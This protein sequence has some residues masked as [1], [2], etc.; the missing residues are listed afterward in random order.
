MEE[1]NLYLLVVKL[2]L[3]KISQELQNEPTI[4]YKKFIKVVRFKAQIKKPVVFFY[5]KM[6]F[7]KYYYLQ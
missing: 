4:T 6:K 1:K 2:S 5:Q 3:S 7:K